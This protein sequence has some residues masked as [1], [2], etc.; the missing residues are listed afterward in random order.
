MQLYNVLVDINKSE[1]FLPGT[2][3]ATDGVRKDKPEPCYV[4]IQ[5]DLA[6][7]IA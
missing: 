5:D 1:D 6:S 2:M 3:V 7:E 4:A